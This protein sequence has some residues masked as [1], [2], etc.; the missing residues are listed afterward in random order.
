LPTK[1]SPEVH[2]QELV[3]DT[4]NWT[5]GLSPKK[6]KTAQKKRARTDSGDTA[7]PAKKKQKTKQGVDS[8]WDSLIANQVFMFSTPHLFS[9]FFRISLHLLVFLLL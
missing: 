5:G 8:E 1:V 2:F 7:G 3:I 4:E 6:R 9:S